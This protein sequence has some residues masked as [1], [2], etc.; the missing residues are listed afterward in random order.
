ME[1]F[2]CYKYEYGIF[3]IVDTVLQLESPEPVRVLGL[4]AVRHWDYDCARDP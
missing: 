3:A 4:S 1:E 2:F